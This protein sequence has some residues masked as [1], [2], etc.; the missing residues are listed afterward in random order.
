M[1]AH[2]RACSILLL[3]ELA[4]F[5][6]AALG[7][8]LC[9]IRR[10]ESQVYTPFSVEDV[11]DLPLLAGKLKTPARPF[12]VWLAA[13]LSSGTQAALASYQGSGAAPEPLRT[14]LV[15]DLD[16]LLDGPS[17]YTPERFAGITLR[18]ETA[19]L[20]SANPQGEDLARLNRRLLEDA[21]PAG[22]AKNLSELW[23]EGTAPPETRYVFQASEDLRNWFD[24]NDEVWGALSHR[25]DSTTVSERFFRLTPWV[26]LDPIVVVLIGD[27]TVSDFMGFYGTGWGRGIY[28]DFKPEA[29]VVNLAWP[30]LSTKIYLT[31]EQHAKLLLIK[32]DFVLIQF[33]HADVY[34]CTGGQ[35]TTTLPEYAD[36]LRAIVGAIRSFGGIPILMT[37][38][39]Q[40]AFGADGK[41]LPIYAD[42]SSAV[43][44]V[45]FE[46][47]TDLVDLNQLS[48]DLFNQLGESGSAYISMG[49]DLD[50]FSIEGAEV[51]AG[52]VVG[53]LPNSLQR[54][55]AR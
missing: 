9:V 10:S 33:G 7:Q 50:H 18:P 16:G 39:A 21:H 2:L 53:A 30:G 38:P 47:Q 36:N 4:L 49:S 31:S 54:Y 3:L 23:V 28:D 11:T 32:P 14:L 35:C 20:L 26:P 41:V 19:A 51:I 12:D 22:L 27:S 45:A 37:P 46:L 48:T 29:R 40:R 24:L 44:D 17:L 5:A 8:S 1:S 15:E 42:R 6:N 52:L 43:R 34:G 25:I 13:A 55:L